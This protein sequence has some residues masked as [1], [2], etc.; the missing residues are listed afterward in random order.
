MAKATRSHASTLTPSTDL[1][2]RVAQLEGRV[3]ALQ[4]LQESARSLTSELVLDQLLAKILQNAVQVMRASAGSLLLYDLTTH[5]LVFSVVQGGGGAALKNTRI[6]FDQGI[7]GAVFTS[8]QP[9]IVHNVQA[10]QRFLKG[11]D[12]KYGFQTTSMIAV[13]MMNKGEPVGVIEVMN[14]ESG[15][16]FNAEDQELLL[17]FAAQSAV[18]IQ[19]ARLYQQVVA[20][21]DRILIVEE[22]VR[23][24]LARDLHDGPAQ[25]I[26]AII[27]E[28]RFL[29]EVITRKPERVQEE[30]THLE[31]L[32]THAL[33]QV[34]NM[35]FDLRPLILETQGLAPALELYVQKQRETDGF[36]L[37]LDTDG[38]TARLVSQSEAAIFSIVQEAVNN[39]RK[40][41][42]AKNVWIVAQ[43]KTGFLTI[44]V[45]DD[46]RGFDVASVEGGYSNRGSLGLLNMKERAEIAHAQ[47]TLSSQVGKGTLVSLV[48]PVEEKSK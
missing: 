9:S 40:H 35:V 33:H 19:N 1:F 32:A 15:D 30:L 28:F 23:R 8:H 4:A 12:T 38:F 41:A 24:E 34:R 10:D 46:G 18:A 6:R 13:P 39:A 16:D 31:E 14:K 43:Q 48:L 27:M 36:N 21:R 20:E 45:Q 25:L 17:A 5:E 29:K 7:A 26:A 47:M 11:I 22:Q 42:E 2:A 3:R 37:H 44:T